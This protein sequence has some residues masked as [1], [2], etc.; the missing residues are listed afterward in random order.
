M[1]QDTN[2]ITFPLKSHAIGLKWAGYIGL[3][4]TGVF[5]LVAHDMG[6]D[7]LTGR[8]WEDYIFELTW[9]YAINSLLIL[10][11]GYLLVNRQKL[12]LLFLFLAFLS[13]IA[14][15]WWSD[16]DINLFMWTISGTMIIPGAQLGAL[17][18]LSAIGV[19]VLRIPWWFKA[20]RIE[21]L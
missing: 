20:T 5:F 3:I 18:F 1:D 17:Y 15:F 10:L 21:M 8:I 4:L 13:I 19:N 11:A 6:N 12:G 2:T 14:S 9:Y 16:G 7:G